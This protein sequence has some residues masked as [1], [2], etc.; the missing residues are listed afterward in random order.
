[1]WILT[2]WVTAIDVPSKRRL[3]TLS[4][5]KTTLDSISPLAPLSV[6]KEG[7]CWACL[8]FIRAQFYSE[9]VGVVLAPR[10][11]IRTPGQLSAPLFR[12]LNGRFFVVEPPWAV[13]DVD[14]DATKLLNATDLVHSFLSKVCKMRPT[15]KCSRCALLKLLFYTA[16]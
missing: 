9:P 12:G 11:E 15:A 13:A 4:T 10:D 5:C 7:C 6:S 8:Q 14:V 16:Q 3:Q 1:M 2:E